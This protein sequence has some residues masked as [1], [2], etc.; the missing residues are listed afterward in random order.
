MDIKNNKILLISSEYPPGPG[1]IGNHA[2][3]LTKALAEKGFEL[4][5]ITNA[6]YAES[7]RIYEFDRSQY[8]NIQII[9]IQRSGIRTYY[10]RIRET[11]KVIKNNKINTILLSGKFSL[12]TG[13]I[14]KML[15]HRL[16]SVAILHGSEVKMSNRFL[17]KF[18]DICISK[19]DF[20]IPV[21]GFTW[22][23][24]NEKLQKKPFQIIENGIDINE[25]QEL[26]RNDSRTFKL[27]GSPAILTV[28]NVTPRKG[29]HRVIKALPEL[30][31]KFPDIHYNVVGLSTYEKQFTELAVSLGVERYVTFYGRLPERSDLA[32]AYKDADCFIILSENQPDGDVE[33]FGIVILEANYFGLPA[34]GARGCGIED[35][36]NDSY[37]GYLVDG[38]NASEIS[39][40]L[41]LILDNKDKLSA[42]S[43][44]W[45]EEHSWDMI[46]DKY[47]TVINTL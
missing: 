16:R 20:I 15:G 12:W 38:D 23:L 29:Q 14:L 46:G 13:G 2:Y 8:K 10:N 5:V 21:S 9:R 3:S 47:V 18:T 45:A 27:K 1:G 28:G 11:I 22:S 36:V 41:T 35:A 30:I 6:D 39:A 44:K 34:I 26:D 33:G 17:R 42:N 4:F 32:A 7:E 31:K 43:V 40:K 37:N 24:L 25:M 19:A